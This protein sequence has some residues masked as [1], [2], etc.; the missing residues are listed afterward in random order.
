MQRI[1]ASLLAF[2]AI[3]VTSTTTSAQSTKWAVDKAHSN[4][5]FTVT[6]M[7]ISEVDGNFKS[8]D[9]TLESAK[10]D[11]S[12]AKIQFSI[13]VASIGT[14]NENRDNHLKGDDF[15]NAA[16]FPKISFTSTS[17]KPLGGNKY[18]LTG[19]MTVR[20]VTKTVTWDVTYGG[21]MSTPRGR[22]AGFKAKATINRFDYN[23]KWNRAME[24]G[25]LVV[26]ENVDVVLNIQLN[27]V[28]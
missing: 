23:L 3:V 18:Q 7:A 26:G 27:E 13:D 9:G 24:A 8:F 12:D 28:K 1:L 25:G 21:I 11:F 4:V 6:H 14:D 22:K 19:T 17:M 15:F 2:S 10:Q 16:Q 20:D 5:K